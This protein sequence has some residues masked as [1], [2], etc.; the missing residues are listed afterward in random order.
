MGGIRPPT[1]WLLFLFQL[2]KQRKQAT[3][4]VLLFGCCKTQGLRTVTGILQ[5]SFT[6]WLL[7]IRL[8]SLICDTRSHPTHAARTEQSKSDNFG[9][10]QPCLHYSTVFLCITLIMVL[11][12]LWG[13]VWTLQI[14]PSG[15]VSLRL[16]LSELIQENNVSNSGLSHIY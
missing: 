3:G 12:A 13:T 1:C 16:S 10:Q 11:V 4:T 7:T 5:A 2:P 15:L 6:S 14:L 8:G 9:V